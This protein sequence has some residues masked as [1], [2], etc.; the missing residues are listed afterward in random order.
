MESVDG[1][2]EGFNDGDLHA[3]FSLFERHRDA[4]LDY[5]RRRKRFDPRL[6]GSTED[7]LHEALTRL[8]SRF[9]RRG[10]RPVLHL[11]PGSFEPYMKR[12][13]SN[14]LSD[15]REGLVLHRPI[16]DQGAAADILEHAPSAEPSPTWNLRREDELLL[17]RD[18]WSRLEPP[19]QEVLVLYILE[20]EQGEER[21]FERMGVRLGLARDAA[22][23]RKYRAER[24]LRELIHR[25]EPSAS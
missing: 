6:N 13:L 8:L 19:E 4:L 15:L 2:Y 21:L 11:D 22:Y 12:I 25:Q 1:L 9:E 23:K 14:L 10:G 7:L 16:A 5:V 3:L 18:A 20:A 17:F 24:R